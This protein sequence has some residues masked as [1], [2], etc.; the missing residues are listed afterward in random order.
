MNFPSGLNRADW[1]APVCVPRRS[2]SP[3]PSARQSRRDRLRPTGR[4]GPEGTLSR[5]F[6]TLVSPE[7]HEEMTAVRQ[8]QRLGYDPRDVRHIALWVV[9][10]VMRGS[11]Q[12]GG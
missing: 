1:I 11:L 6:L 12:C 5:F 9:L 2:G 8:I 10:L 7:F 4:R 3:V